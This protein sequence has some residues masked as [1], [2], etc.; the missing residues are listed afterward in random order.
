MQDK[1]MQQG[2]S[3]ALKAL[4]FIFERLAYVSIIVCFDLESLGLCLSNSFMVVDRY[5]A[6]CLPQSGVLRDAVV[7]I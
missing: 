4:G 7:L 3:P 1:R 6:Q 2:C 5:L